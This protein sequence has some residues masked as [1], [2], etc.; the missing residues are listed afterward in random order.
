MK[1]RPILKLK[2]SAERFQQRMRVK[3][4]IERTMKV[5]LKSKLIYSSELIYHGLVFGITSLSMFLLRRPEYLLLAGL[6]KIF[7][8]V[9]MLLFSSGYMF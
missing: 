6:A 4:I 5:L 9:K 7:G 1:W 8:F 2:P 3:M